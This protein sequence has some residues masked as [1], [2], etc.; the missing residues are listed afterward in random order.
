MSSRRDVVFG[1]IGRGEKGNKDQNRHEHG[2]GK[3]RPDYTL[4]PRVQWVHLTVPSSVGTEITNI[5]RWGVGL[6]KEIPSPAFRND[7]DEVRGAAGIMDPLTPNRVAFPGFGG[8]KLTWLRQKASSLEARLARRPA[9]SRVP[10]VGRP[11]YL[12]QSSYRSLGPIAGKARLQNRT[13]SFCLIRLLYRWRILSRII[14]PSG[15]IVGPNELDRHCGTCQGTTFRRESPTLFL[16]LWGDEALS[17]LAST[18]LFIKVDQEFSVF[19]GATGKLYSLLLMFECHS[20]DDR[21]RLSVLSEWLRVP[22][23]NSV[24]REMLRD[25]KSCPRGLILYRERALGTCCRSFPRFGK[26]FPLKDCQDWKYFCEFRIRKLK[27]MPR[28][29]DF[30]G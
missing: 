7:E 15:R 13:W 24:I 4:V 30:L 16:E 1:R 10:V 23:L 5:H 19:W 22:E 25:K 2:T 27:L 11:P 29:P 6:R 12:N 18:F 26:G 14:N 28:R 20:T 8:L 9:C 3:N 17:T 21:K